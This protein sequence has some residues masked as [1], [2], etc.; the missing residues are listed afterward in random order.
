MPQS[1]SE[2]RTFLRFLTPGT[3]PIPR[4]ML[5][6]LKSLGVGMNTG[7]HFANSRF[8][9][10]A[11]M[12]DWAGNLMDLYYRAVGLPRWDDFFEVGMAS[13]LANH[14]T[15]LTGKAFEDLSPEVQ[16]TMSE[17]TGTIAA[18]DVPSGA[19]T[20]TCSLT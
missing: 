14:A 8:G 4:D 17:V 5:S 12:H 15:R 6:T 19:Q 18:A 1:R 20:L 7:A 13:G 9:G 16:R 3:R 2:E 11:D 10:G